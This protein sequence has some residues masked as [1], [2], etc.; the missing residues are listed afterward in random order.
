MPRHCFEVFS[1]TDTMPG[2]TDAEIGPANS[3]HAAAQYR[4]FDEDFVFLYRG[5]TFFHK[6]F[7]VL[8]IYCNDALTSPLT[9]AKVV[10]HFGVIKKA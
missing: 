10:T 9:L 4:N 7:I 1:K 3:L 2:C 6:T 5:K 8:G